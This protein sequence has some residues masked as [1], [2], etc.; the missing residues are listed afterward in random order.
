MQHITLSGRKYIQRDVE[1]MKGQWEFVIL[2]REKSQRR[3][4]TDRKKR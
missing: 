2:K 4:R 3:K 1:I